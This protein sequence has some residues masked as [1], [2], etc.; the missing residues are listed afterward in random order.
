MAASGEVTPSLIWELL[1]LRRAGPRWEVG[2][3]KN[4]SSD[5]VSLG[6]QRRHYRGLSKTTVEDTALWGSV[7]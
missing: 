7:S 5:P 4:P 2:L 6:R 1:G 3:K